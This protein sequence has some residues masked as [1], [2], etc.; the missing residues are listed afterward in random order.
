MTP[1]ECRL[2]D[3][4]Y[5]GTICVDIEYVRG[6]QV[7]V[8]RNIEIGRM[9]IMLKSSKCVLTGK[10]PQ[11][12]VNMGECPL[13]PGNCYHY[14]SPGGY[15]VIRGVEKVILIQEQLSKNRIIVET[16]R[17][18][19]IGANVTSSTHE[20]KSKTAVLL[21]KNSRVVLKHNSLTVDV[22]IVI[23]L[24]AMGVESDREIAELVCGNDSDF[25]D[26]FLPS[27]E[28]AAHANVF[29][30]KQAM[31]WLG[32]KVKMN[33]AGH[34]WGVKRNLPEEAKDL[35][36]TT[37]L[38]HIP[39]EII[40]GQPNFRPK[41]VYIALMVRRTLQAVRDGGVVDDRDFVG[42]KRLEL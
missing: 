33:M 28:E 17:V 13:D 4:T 42:N 32:T 22:P 31:E 41:S 16:D 23:V 27:L 24:K 20:K 12:I 14:S 11:E 30:Q 10:S 38:A 3:I 40:N 39:V 29:T 26:L 25:M 2:R 7:V 6:K 37:V 8:K 18:G 15:F 34:R 21:G 9:P 35:L 36:V 19:C 1:Q 5:A